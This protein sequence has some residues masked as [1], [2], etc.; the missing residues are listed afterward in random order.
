MDSTKLHRNLPN[1]MERFLVKCKEVCE[2]CCDWYV[3]MGRYFRRNKYLVY[4]IIAAIIISLLTI[5]ILLNISLNYYA[6]SSYFA[7]KI[8]GLYVFIGPIILPMYYFVI[9]EQKTLSPSSLILNWYQDKSNLIAF[10]FTII[11]TVAIKITYA[12]EDMTNTIILSDIWHLMTIIY[13]IWCICFFFLIFN[14]IAAF[15]QHTKLERLIAITIEEIKYLIFKCICNKC[16]IDNNISEYRVLV[17]LTESYYQLIRSAIG[18]GLVNIYSDSYNVWVDSVVG[19]IFRHFQDR[20]YLDIQM[21]YRDVKFDEFYKCL[22]HSQVAMIKDLYLSEHAN[23]GYRALL[24]L[25]NWSPRGVDLASIKNNDTRLE[26]L[27]KR[28]DDMTG[29]YVKL[30]GEMGLF[31][32]RHDL[33]ISPITIQIREMIYSLDINLVLSIYRMWLIKIVESYDLKKLIT[34][35]YELMETVI[36]GIREPN[37]EEN[38]SDLSKQINGKLLLSELEKRLT[39]NDSYVGMALFILYNAAV[40]SLELSRYRFAGFLVKFVTTNFSSKIVNSTFDMFYKKEGV[41]EKFETLKFSQELGLKT[42]NV[43]QRTNVYCIEKLALLIYCQQEYIIQNNVKFK[44]SG[45]VNTIPIGQYIKENK[46]YLF[47]KVCK[48]SSN[49]GLMW[50]KDRH[51]LGELRLYFSRA[52]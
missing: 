4:T 12:F 14:M 17:K 9:R 51:F 7:K 21:S 40:K 8:S 34:L 36:Y 31:F 26:E 29:E 35:S 52:K 47:N 2:K 37:L 50:M 10:A 18:K 27:K 33:V 3:E 41:D 44:R 32:Y 19:E 49:Y 11:G 6:V 30:I 20:P 39:M 38:F 22:I 25:F 42:F 24:D 16:I 13:I 45:D 5:M 43:N 28:I 15:F 48:Q 1:K 46:E 23:V